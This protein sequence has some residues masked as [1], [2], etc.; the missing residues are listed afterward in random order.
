MYIFSVIYDIAVCKEL[1]LYRAVTSRPIK[2]LNSAQDK[3]IKQQ[4]YHHIQQ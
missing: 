2:T 4:N 1:C 3:M